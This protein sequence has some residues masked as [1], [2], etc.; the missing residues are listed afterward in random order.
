MYNVPPKRAIVKALKRRKLNP[1]LFEKQLWKNSFG[2]TALDD[3]KDGIQ[4]ND[5][6]NNSLLNSKNMF[7]LKNMINNKNYNSKKKRGLMRRQ[8]TSLR[9]QL[10]NLEKTILG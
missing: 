9:F 4:N 6:I 1:I 5:M 7:S 8:E 3:D 2:Q 10:A